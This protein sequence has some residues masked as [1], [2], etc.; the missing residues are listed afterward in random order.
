VG[1]TKKPNPL[2][3]QALGEMIMLEGTGCFERE[4]LLPLRAVLRV[5]LL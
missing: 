2:K 5:T 4:N 1:K 3:I